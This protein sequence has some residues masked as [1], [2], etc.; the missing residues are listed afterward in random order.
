MDVADGWR[1]SRCGRSPSRRCESGLWVRRAGAAGRW[2]GAG[3][4]PASAQRIWPAR[5]IKPRR[6]KTSRR[7]DDKRFE[8][9]PVGVVGLCASPPQN[10]GRAVH[11]RSLPDPG[12]GARP[13]GRKRPCEGRNSS[14]MSYF[15]P[16]P[17]TPGRRARERQ[18]VAAA[19]PRLSPALRPR[20]GRRDRS[21]SASQRREPAAVRLGLD[22]RADPHEG[23]P[24]PAR[25]RRSHPPKL[26]TPQ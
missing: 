24:W 3:V 23:P 16:H 10:A 5:N 18:S 6:T 20:P 11:R 15:A 13:G 7:S 17:Q 12:A 22:R 25:P 1:R 8:R 26:K 2:P 21:R 9:R 4:S 14:K 19:P